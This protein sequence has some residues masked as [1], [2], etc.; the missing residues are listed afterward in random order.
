MR[1]IVVSL[2]REDFIRLKGDLPFYDAV[3]SLEVLQILRA[4]PEGAS[5]VVTLRPKDP[6]AK[7]SA[8]AELVPARLRLL[9]A[10][11]GAF[12]C[13]MQFPTRSTHGLLGLRPDQGYFIPPIEVVADTARITYVGSSAD[14]ARLLTGL[15][16]SGLRFRT[17]SISDLRLSPQSPL[18]A[19]TDKQ[20]RV[21]SA[22]Y[23]RGY[24]DRPRRVSSR[25]LA[26]SLGMS[27]SNL[28]NHRLKAERRLLSVILNRDGAGPRGRR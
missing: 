23:A 2:P 19:L 7:F 4:G 6:A 3:A 15:R 10:A 5:S 20:R 1:R 25:A 9:D 21:V 12:T 28:V 17:L 13:L 16:R 18:N 27:S 24:Y 26:R 22:A 11:D 14:V 8:L